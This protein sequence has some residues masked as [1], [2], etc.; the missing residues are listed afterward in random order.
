MLGTQLVQLR[1][2]SLN[3]WLLPWSD[4]RGFLLDIR[5]QARDFM[6]NLNT[7]KPVLFNRII[8]RAV[9]LQRSV[10]GLFEGCFVGW[11]WGGS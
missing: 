2:S 8:A 7:F 9:L 4:C 10:F 6:L 3:M 5:F 11:L 1:C